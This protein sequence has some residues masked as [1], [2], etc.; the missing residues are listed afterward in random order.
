MTSAMQA[1]RAEQGAEQ[2]NGALRLRVSGVVQGV[3]FRP[4]VHRLAARHALRGWVRNTT[5]DVEIAVA[6]EALELERFVAAIAAEAPPLARVDRVERE[7]ADDA[8]LGPFRIVESDG[9]GDRGQ[10]VSPDV[11]TCDE[12]EAELF[13]PENRRHRYPFITCTNCGPRYSVIERMPYDRERT[14]MRA[15]AQCPECRREYDG[16]GDRRYHSE[17]NSCPVCGPRLSF[18]DRRGAEIV[19]AGPIESAAAVIR[20]GGIVA[21][22]GVGGFHLACD[23]T[24]E[25]AVARLRRGKHRDGKPLAVMV[26]GLA[27]ARALALVSDDEAEWLRRPSRPIVVLDAREGSPVPASVSGGLSTIGV[28]LAYTPAHLLLLEA[29]GRPLVMTS[30]NHSGEPLAASLSEALCD[31]AEVADAYLTHDRDIVAR[32]DDSVLRV[33]RGAAKDAAGR[34][35]AIL[36]RRARGFAPLPLSLPVPATTPIV[37]VGPHLKN[38]LCL[39]IGRDAY[40]SAHVGDLETLDTAEHWQNVYDGM[41][42]LFRIE[43][44]VVARD[45]H[46]GYL[47]TRIA[48]DLG[49]AHVLEVQHHHAHVAAVAAEHGITEPVI[50]VAFDGTGYGDDGHTWGAEILVGDL[51]NYRRAAH[52][53]YAPLPGGDLA[54]RSPWRVA[55]GYASLAPEAREAF[56][57]AWQG[58]SSAAV[59]T[60]ERQIDERV[61]TPVASSMGRLFDAAAAVLGV[62]RESRFE[63]EAAIQLES[64]AARHRADPLPYNAVQQGDGHFEFDPLPLLVALGDRARRG[65][66]VGRLAAAFHESVAEGTAA[67]V[68]SLAAREGIS[69]VALGG[70]VFQNAR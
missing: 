26:R 69:R 24:S 47:S 51:V 37:A 15:F 16:M 31:L 61:N 66:D 13:D 55:L 34:A 7:P 3:G 33:P 25:H 65:D 40:V 12:C 9:A 1:G 67:L 58:V 27:E 62:C 59:R 10:W 17:T 22:R 56:A 68:G 70:G 29:V 53:Q 45:L 11:A 20:G 4:F 41:R 39:G 49:I 36:M 23:A 30:G 48:G 64:R 14:S 50:G 57:M 44:A 32:I 38:T 46:P 63:G 18:L 19:A 42:E 2:A 8:D 35:P 52:L 60:V 6:G 21:V 5:G 54:A 28:M 43:P